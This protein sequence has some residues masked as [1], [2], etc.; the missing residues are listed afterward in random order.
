VMQFR[1]FRHFDS[2]LGALHHVNVGIVA[3]ILDVLHAASIF[4]IEV[5]RADECPC[6]S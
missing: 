3:D 1:C 4:S 5:S 6:M 2:A